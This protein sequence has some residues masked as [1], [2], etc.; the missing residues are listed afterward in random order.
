MSLLISV[1]DK[2][3]VVAYKIW[4]KFLTVFGD[5]Y[6]ATSLPAVNAHDIRILMQVVKP[7]D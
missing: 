6:F 1:H 7:G 5:L 2:I 3:C 4:S